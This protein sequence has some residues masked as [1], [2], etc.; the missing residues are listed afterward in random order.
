[1]AKLKNKENPLRTIQVP[2]E[3]YRDFLRVAADRVKPFADLYLLKQQYASDV[4]DAPMTVLDLVCQ[5]YLQGIYDGVEL[6]TLRP[7][8]LEI[9]R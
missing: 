1:M 3:Q 7:E 8:V 2:R 6:A 4:V 5:V 9:M